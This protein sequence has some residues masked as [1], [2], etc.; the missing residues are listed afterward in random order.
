MTIRSLTDN[1]RRQVRTQLRDAVARTVRR[2]DELRGRIA[3]LEAEIVDLDRL[4]S[5]ALGAIE[6]IEATPEVTT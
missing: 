6:I 1:G 4:R 3:A 5:A 2:A